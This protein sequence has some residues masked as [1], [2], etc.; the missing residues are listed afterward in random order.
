MNGLTSSH[1]ESDNKTDSPE[2]GSPAIT[3]RI[4][5]VV[6]VGRPNVGKSTLF[7][8]MVGKRRAITDP[9]PG[10]TRDAVRSRALINDRPV[11]L[12]DTGGYRIDAQDIDSL[13]R[14]K[15]LEL[16]KQADLVLFICDVQDM[17]AEDESF[18]EHLRPYARKVILVVNKV[19]NPQREQTL[20][21]FHSF[22]FEQVIGISA[23]HGLGIDVLEEQIIK[24]IDFENFGSSEEEV[25]RIR[26][27]VLGKPNT[28]KSTLSNRLVGSEASIVSEI[29]G[30]TRDVIEGSFTYK[31]SLYQIMDTAG[32]RKKKKVNESVEYYSV[33][34]AIKTIEESDVVFLMVDAE[35]GLTEQDKKISAQAVKKGRGIIL[36]LNKWDRIE[37]TPNVQ[38]AVKDRTRYIFPVLGFA[39]LIP[40]SATTGEGVE[41]LLDAAYRVWKQLNKRVETPV[42]NDLIQK[43]V[44]NY[45]P[46][47]DSRG[48][49]KIYYAT[50]V[51]ADPVRFVL[52]VNRKKGFPKS[53]IQYI[54]NS[55][56][57]EL[58]FP[59]IPLR[60]DLRERSGHKK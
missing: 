14:G 48:H 54:V 26:L 19:D 53:Y 55:I 60:V 33:N 35:E 50:Q 24:S 45:P 11:E 2:T 8:R 1:S 22:G 37:K 23:A 38:Q 36:V 58:G 30:T 46:P 39:P 57:A 7:N 25:P 34:R 18:I 41:K 40:I 47:R 43:L 15:S 28:G 9:M 3:G 12:I 16:V 31:G 51:E 20:W 59:D 42:I 29:P 49:H 27:A 21:N 32:I 17:N 13:V 56:R 4:P 5:K 10:V 52:F 6:V 44:A